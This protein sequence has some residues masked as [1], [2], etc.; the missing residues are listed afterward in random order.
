MLELELNDITFLIEGR[1]KFCKMIQYGSR[2]IKHQAEGNN[3][4][5]FIAFKGLFG[6]LI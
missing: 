4:A 3:E 6:R 1:D 2:L 5:I